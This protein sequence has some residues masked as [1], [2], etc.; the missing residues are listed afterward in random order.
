MPGRTKS[1]GPPTLLL[2][3][4]VLLL[5]SPHSQ[6]QPPLQ[7]PAGTGTTL[8]AEGLGPAPGVVLQALSLDAL[9][10]LFL[11]QLKAGSHNR[12]S[13]GS[14]ASGILYVISSAPV[15]V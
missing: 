14:V 1:L 2:P 11:S 12:S 15:S 9:P 4:S 6:G 10:S 8:S 5:E 7:T 3:S 13:K